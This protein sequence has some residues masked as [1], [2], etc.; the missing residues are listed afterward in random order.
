MIYCM[1]TP[2]GDRPADERTMAVRQEL[3]DQACG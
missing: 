3:D 1:S 2:D